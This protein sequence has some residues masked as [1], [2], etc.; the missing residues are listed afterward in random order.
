MR[1]WKCKGWTYVVENQ[2]RGLPQVHILL[3]LHP[4]ACP[5]TTVD[6]DSLICAE[7]PVREMY[8]ELWDTIMSRMLHGPYRPAINPSCTCIVKGRCKSHYSWPVQ[9]TSTFQED[10][11]SLYHRHND[12]RKFK[13]LGFSFTNQWVV[14]DNPYLSAKYNA[15]IDVEVASSIMSIKYLLKYVY[16]G[17]DRSA[18]IV[19]SPGIPVNEI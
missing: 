6:L 12:G 9:K 13:H 2:K 16:R 1:V 5:K 7:L 14:P 3:I 11:Y 10:R 19:H 4:H 18:F 8:P 15:H 17:C